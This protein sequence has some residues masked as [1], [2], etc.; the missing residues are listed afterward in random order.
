MRCQPRC[1]VTYTHT[2]IV[3]GI[4]YYYVDSIDLPMCMCGTYIQSE[5]RH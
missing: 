4:E 3:V 5:L 1:D 2:Y